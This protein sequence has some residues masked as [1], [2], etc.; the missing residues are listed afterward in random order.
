MHLVTNK[1]LSQ[2]R[3]ILLYTFCMASIY[4]TIGSIEP[5]YILKNWTIRQVFIFQN[6][7]GKIYITKLAIGMRYHMKNAF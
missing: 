5:M 7:S 1:F 4:L 6:N 3:F 2:S